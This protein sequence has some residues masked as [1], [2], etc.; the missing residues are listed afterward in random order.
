MRIT[1]TDLSVVGSGYFYCNK[2]I[3]LALSLA[4]YFVSNS[5]NM[6]VRALEDHDKDSKDQLG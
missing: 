2:A 5:V 6:Q 3:G 1:Y 4:L